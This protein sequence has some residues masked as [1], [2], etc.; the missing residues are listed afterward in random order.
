[1]GCRVSTSLSEHKREAA[2]LSNAARA[3]LA[4]SIIASL[5]PPVDDMDADDEWIREIERRTDQIDCG[6][7]RAEFR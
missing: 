7:V 4:L 3:E 6:D 2:K 1:V 5:E